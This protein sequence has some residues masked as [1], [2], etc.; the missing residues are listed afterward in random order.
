MAEN[1]NAAIWL[2]ERHLSEGR[3]AKAAFREAGGDR[4][5]LS[6]GALS[7]ESDRAAGAFERAGIRREERALLLVLDQIE[8]PVLF[9]GAIKAGIVAVPLNT[10]LATSS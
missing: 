8:F 9:W 4:R 6:Y 10:L 2:V 1:G 5:S 3:G 7:A